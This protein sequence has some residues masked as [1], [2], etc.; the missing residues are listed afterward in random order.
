MNFSHWIMTVH[1]H[2]YLIFHMS[3]PCG[4][5]YLKAT[6]LQNS[7][8]MLQS[9]CSLGLSANQLTVFF[10]HIKSA[11]ATSHRQANRV[12]QPFSCV[13]Q[14]KM[15]APFYVL[16]SS[17]P[18]HGAGYYDS[19]ILMLLLSGGTDHVNRQCVYFRK[20]NRQCVLTRSCYLIGQFNLILLFHGH[21]PSIVKSIEFFVLPSTV[22]QN[23]RRLA[24]K[25]CCSNTCW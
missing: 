22:E 25:Y 21:C 17:F 9:L 12:V 23:K 6:V 16:S 24:L 1:F 5:K 10:S 15:T 3:H 13:A 19:G 2:C 18:F 20:K 7:A 11:P 8:L 4:S 14:L